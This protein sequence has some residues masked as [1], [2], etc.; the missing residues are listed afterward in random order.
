M[1][2][3]LYLQATR[4]DVTYVVNVLSQFV[5]DPRQNHLEATNR[6]LRYLKG[7]PSQGIL[8]PREGPLTLTAYCDSD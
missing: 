3:L 4:P 5:S 8:L 6:V 2:R 1:G 7:T